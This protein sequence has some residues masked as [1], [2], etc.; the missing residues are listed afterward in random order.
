MYLFFRLLLLIALA[1]G[2]P[3]R[4]AALAQA[5]PAVPLAATITGY[6]LVDATTDLDLF[7]LTPGI[8]LDLATLPAQLNIRA[9]TDLTPVG[10][11]VFALTGAET[12]AEVQNIVPYALFSD[13]NGDYY[14]WVPSL[15]SYTLLA[16]PYDAPDGAGA[17]GAPLTLSFSVINSVG[18]VTS[19]TLVDADTDLDIATVPPGSALD[20]A[21]LPTRNIN[22]RANT[23]LPVVGSVVFS[24]TGPET[25][26]STENLPP[27]ALFSDFNGNYAAWTPTRG[28]YQLVA[29]P[30]AGSNGSGAAG[31]GLTLG[32]QITDSAAPLAVQLTSFTA[33]ASAAASV[34]LRWTTASEEN[35]REF[36]IERS[37]D[38]KL[39]STVGSVAGHGTSSTAH[40][41]SYADKQLPAS[42][43]TLYYRLRQVDFDGTTNFSPVRQVTVP[44]GPKA[45]QVYAALVP[46]GLLHYVF[47]GPLTGIES[48]TLYTM[49][50]Q[51]CGQYRMAATGTGTLAVASLPAGAYVLWLDSPAGHFSSRVVLP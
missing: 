39:F 48:M 42:T 10:S 32:F 38:G 47:S 30:Y 28:T 15:G 3:F 18:A 13:L 26:V 37:S 23:S 17:V 44:T 9:N 40:T 19:F 25:R 41:Y 7:D 5:G 34:L 22:I 29:T 50:G 6:T 4:P 16:T 14:G 35:N 20:L 27:Y 36:A 45:L 8:V 24:L 12:H 31:V 49:L 11:V 33:E 2:A 51:R 43:T 21:M 46:D 1:C